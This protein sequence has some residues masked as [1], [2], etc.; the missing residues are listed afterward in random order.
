MGVRHKKYPHIQVRG[1]RGGVGKRGRA[2][3]EDGTIT[4]GRGTR[5]TRISRCSR[6][7]QVQWVLAGRRGRVGG[8]GPGWSWAGVAGLR[9]HTSPRHGTARNTLSGDPEPCQRTGAGGAGKRPA[10]PLPPQHRFALPQPLP[11]ASPLFSPRGC[12]LRHIAKILHRLHSLLCPALIPRRACSSTPSPSSPRTA[13]AS[14]PTS[15]RRWTPRRARR[16]AEQ[17]FGDAKRRWTPTEQCWCSA[18]VV[19]RAVPWRVLG[20]TGRRW[21]RWTARGEAAL[22]AGGWQ[23]E[24]ACRVGAGSSW[25]QPL[26]GRGTGGS[27]AYEG[28]LLACPAGAAARPLVLCRLAVGGW[29]AWGASREGGGGETWGGGHGAGE[30]ASR[31]QQQQ[32][33]RRQRRKGWWRRQWGA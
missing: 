18:K 5:S 20:G 25:G 11:S 31:Q 22:E 16:R 7:S 4:G 8:L 13:S 3:T 32:R 27:W 17:C 9:R 21:E 30:R 10:S 14:L 19:P 1:A 29:G 33:W 12:R 6:V 26:C 24:A 2:W 15:S 28:R 23:G